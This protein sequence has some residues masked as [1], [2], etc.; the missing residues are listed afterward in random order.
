MQAAIVGVGLY[1]PSGDSG[2]Y[3]GYGN[4]ITPQFPASSPWVTAVGGTTLVLGKGSKPYKY[5]LPWGWTECSLK[6]THCNYTG[7]G[8]SGGVANY[9][10]SPFFQARQPQVQAVL[11]ASGYKNGRVVPDISAD[12]DPLMGYV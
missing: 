10:A 5:E 12:G 9:Y 11:H 1:F 6:H 4:F 2:E 3:D 7:E 8:T